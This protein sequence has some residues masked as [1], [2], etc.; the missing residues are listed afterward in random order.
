MNLALNGIG[1]ARRLPVLMYHH[2]SD[3]PGLVTVSPATFR[4]H[5]EWLARNGWTTVGT[6][7]VEAFYAG[8]PLPR[9]SVVVTFDDGY[10]DNYLHA[11]PVLKE[12]GQKAVLFVVTGWMGAGAPRTSAGCP[13][14]KQCKALIANGAADQVILRWSE[15]E[16]MQTEGT[17]EFHSHT[18]S[19]TR[20]DK[21]LLP[22]ADRLDAMREE[23]TRS[24]ELLESRLGVRTRHLCWPQGYYEA[25][26]LPLA[27]DAGYSY[28]YTTEPR[29]NK[30][31][32]DPLRVGRIV[33]KERPGGWLGRRLAIYAT[34][35]LAEL[36][37]YRK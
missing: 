21:Q 17:F 28:L 4:S 2:V 15:A 31:S 10:L 12:F 13:D 3:S 1:H 7:D 37:A 32:D 11:R 19:H 23:L 18:H 22:G 20:W 36:Y 30:P 29:S 5:M 14:H 8:R 26:Y 35:L 25:D 24:A 34:P 27:R 33:T 6:K 9:K 16:A